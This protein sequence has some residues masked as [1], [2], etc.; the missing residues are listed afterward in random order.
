MAIRS[1]ADGNSPSTASFIGYREWK[2][3]PGDIEQDIVAKAQNIE[4]R[5]FKCP[6]CT[7][8][9]ENDLVEF[10]RFYCLEI[11]EAVL[12]GFNLELKMDVVGV[13]PNG[14]DFCE[15]VFYDMNEK[16]PNPGE[17][18]VMPWDYHTGHLYAAAGGVINKE[19][20]PKSTDAIN[21]AFE[22]FHEC[23][24]GNAARIVSDYGY[25]D[26]T[27]PPT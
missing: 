2:V 17:N 20:G 22:N 8:W 3:N 5:V 19:L 15:F 18:A 4:M 7:A 9:E 27:R 11:D 16:P 10:G 14:V 6:W 24:G 12:R 26:F 23:F 1:L 25:T 13:R 21:S